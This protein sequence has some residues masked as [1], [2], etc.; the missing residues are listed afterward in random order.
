M[1]MK[2]IFL[3]TVNIAE[4]SVIPGIDIIG[5]TTLSELVEMLLGERPII[6]SPHLDIQS[7]PRTHMTVDFSSIHGQE[8]AKRALLIAAA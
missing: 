1:G 7:I 5:V 3:P 8:Q 6:A 2:R 4:A